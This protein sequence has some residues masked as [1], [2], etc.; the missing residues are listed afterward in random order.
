MELGNSHVLQERWSRLQTAMKHASVD[1]VVITSPASVYYFTGIWVGTGERASA[2]VARIHNNPVWVIHEM[3]Q[4]EVSGAQIDKQ[5]WRDGDNPYPMIAGLLP[6]DAK[7]AVDG[8]WETRHLLSL[9]SARSA[10]PL[11]VVADAI[12]ASLRYKKDESELQKLVRASEMADEVVKAIR[13]HLNPQTTELQ[14][15]KELERL[16]QQVGA[17]GMSF[18]AIIASGVSGSAP[19]HEPGD[20]PIQSGTTVIV[21]T[22]GL[23]QHYVSDITRTFIVGRPSEE[24]RNVYSCV[25]AANEAGIAAAKPGVTLGDVD[26]VVRKVITDAGYGEYFTHRTGHGV[27]LSVHEEPF[28]IGG[29]DDVLAPGMV[30]SIEPGIYLP[31]KFGVRIEDLIVIEELGARAL[32]RAPKQLEDVVLEV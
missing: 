3:F 27:G 32:N 20:A 21:D 13:T 5:F 4:V 17:E 7:I 23:H 25:L 11:P 29:N 19:H 16:W 14:A 18:P 1:A 30:M 9:T 31:G 8:T 6:A 12:L 26:A 2:L 24:V 22:G 15:A 28:V 10:A